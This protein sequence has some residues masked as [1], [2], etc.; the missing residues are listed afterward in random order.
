MGSFR[1]TAGNRHLHRYCIF[2][3]RIPETVLQLLHY[4]CAS[5]LHVIPLFLVALTISSSSTLRH[6]EASADYGNFLILYHLSYQ[7]GNLSRYGVISLRLRLPTVL[8]EHICA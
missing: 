3:E 1:L 6:V 5:E 8:P 7:K 2:T 4:S